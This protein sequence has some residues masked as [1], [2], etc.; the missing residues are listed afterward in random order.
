MAEAARRSRAFCSGRSRSAA[1]NTHRV[2]SV[3]AVRHPIRRQD[4]RPNGKATL[5]LSKQRCGIGVAEGGEV[6]KRGNNQKD[7]ECASTL[8]MEAFMFVYV[9]VCV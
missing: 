4:Q 5:V 9:C 3:D 7:G 6:L 1:D 2:R 8:G